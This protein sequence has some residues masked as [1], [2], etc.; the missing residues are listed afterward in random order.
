MKNSEK[1][2]SELSHDQMIKNLI[3]DYPIDALDFFEPNI[4][5]HYGKPI[6]I[7]FNIQEIQKHSHYDVNLTNDI[8]V[9]Y[10]FKNNK[11]IV[12][13]LIEHWSDKSKFD[14]Y[15]FSHYFIDI[16][17]RFPDAE[18]LPIALF[19]DRSGI[20]QKNP[21]DQIEISCFGKRYLSFEYKLIRLK[22]HKAEKYRETKN[23]FIAVLK[24]AMKYEIDKKTAIALELIKN[25]KHIEA[26]LRLFMKNL[27]IIEFFLEITGEEKNY[28]IKTM[29]E[30]R[31]ANMIVQELM[32]RGYDKGIHDGIEQ[33]IEKGIEK[34]IEQGIEKGKVEALK[35]T[36]N[37]LQKKGLSSNE[38]SD[39]TG[40]SIEDI[41]KISILTN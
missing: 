24:S 37:N 18:I 26:D 14:I 4:I 7:D 31:E 1:E 36:I 20:W 5:K 19:T 29:E 33:G 35:I 41:Q 28:I 17:N 10:T 2:S 40:I 39:I 34:G 9:T 3:R 23:R 15:R 32:K 21:P 8:A 30:E 22:D 13:V 12:V 38:I 25:F 16:A 11:R 27:D 6:R